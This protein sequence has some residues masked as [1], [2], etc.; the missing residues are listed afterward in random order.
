M[1]SLKSKIQYVYIIT[2]SEN[3]K[4]EKLKILYTSYIKIKSGSVD[5]IRII[6]V[7]LYY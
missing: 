2:F 6:I 5:K 3:F 4:K 7:L 1:F